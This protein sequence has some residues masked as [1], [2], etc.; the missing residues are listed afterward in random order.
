MLLVQ[1][2]VAVTLPSTSYGHFSSESYSSGSSYSSVQ[3]L[4]GGGGFSALSIGSLGGPGIPGGGAPDICHGGTGVLDDDGCRYESDFDSCM[5][6]CTETWVNWK[7]CPD[8]LY[9]CKLSCG[10]QPEPMPLD[11]GLTIMLL[12]SAASAGLTLLRKRLSVKR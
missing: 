12:F 8:R 1:N 10:W 2:V 11:G 6:C 9:E 7:D 5:E 3:M 4:E